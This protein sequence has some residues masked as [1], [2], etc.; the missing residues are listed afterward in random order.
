[1]T[2]QGRPNDMSTIL[3]SAAVLRFLGARFPGR[4]TFIKGFSDHEI[5]ATKTPAIRHC[6]VWS[7][8]GVHSPQAVSRASLIAP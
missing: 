7:I 2:S 8:D 1:M 5:N 3:F 4:T 6:D